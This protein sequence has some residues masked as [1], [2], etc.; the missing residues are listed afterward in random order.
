MSTTIDG[1]SRRRAIIVGAGQA[2][3]AVAAALIAEGLQPQTD[4]ALVDAAPPG[5]R[6]WRH[7]RHSLRLHTTARESALTGLEFPGNQ[8]RHPRADEMTSYLQ[9][10]ADHFGVVPIWDVAALGVRRPGEGTTLELATT[11][12]TIQTRNVVAATGAYDVPRRPDWAFE[13][14]VPGVILHSHQYMYPRQVPPGRVLVVGGGQAAVEVATELALSHEV[15]LSTRNRTID[16]ALR[17]HRHL[18]ASQED[19]QALPA[20]SVT[21]VPEVIGTTGQIVVL[22]DGR[23]FEVDS[24]VL[25]TG[26]LPGDHWLPDAVTPRLRSRATDTALPGLFVV[27]I[28]GY[29]DRHAARIARVSRPARRVARRILERP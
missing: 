29:G 20:G 27:G 6:S 12:G 21:V 18:L 22:R 17:V 8:R 19:A 25:A 7:R 23:R 13:L 5:E 1:L 28:P 10:F 3:L 11:E 9:T 2:G 14:R 15:V 16:R 24:A 26:Y 4:F